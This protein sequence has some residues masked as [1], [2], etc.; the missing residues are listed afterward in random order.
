MLSVHACA[1]KKEKGNFGKHTAHAAHAAHT[2]G[3]SKI[4]MENECGMTFEK[5]SHHLIVLDMG[6]RTG[7]MP[8]QGGTEQ[9]NSNA[10]RRS[11]AIFLDVYGKA[12]AGFVCR[13][14]RSQCRSISIISV[15]RVSEHTFHNIVLLY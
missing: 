3:K 13:R 15:L 9:T 14:R 4:I 8:A 2:K 6:A 12:R 7:R 1:S 5:L 11:P 10:A